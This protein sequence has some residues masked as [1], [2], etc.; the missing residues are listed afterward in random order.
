MRIIGLLQKVARWRRE[1]DYLIM[2][3]LLL[4]SVII[5]AGYRGVV[6]REMFTYDDQLPIYVSIAS[7]MTEH[8][9]SY[10]RTEAHL[11]KENPE[12][13]VYSA[14]GSKY[15]ADSPM[16][17]EIGW[18]LA[19]RVILKNGIKGFE[20][21]AR[22]IG[23]YQIMLDLIVVIILFFVGRKMFGNL[24]GFV[25]AVLYA[26]FRMPMVM[27]SEVKYYYW[28]IPISAVSLMFWVLIYGGMSRNAKKHWLYVSLFLY[29][30]F[31]GFATA[32]RVYF[33]LLPL[34]LV[35]FMLAKER[36]FKKVVL[37]FMIIMLGQSVFVIP[38]MINNKIH[39]RKFAVTVRG[40][41]H[42]FLQGVGLYPDNPWGI[43]D[44]GE[45]NLNVWGKA[46]GAP[47][48]FQSISR[49]EKWYR[50]RYFEMVAERPDIFIRNFSKHLKNG[51][52]YVHPHNYHFYGVTDNL[53]T[54]VRS[55]ITLLP[56]DH[57]LT[58]VVR[59]G[60][61]RSSPV[62]GLTAFYL[63]KGPITDKHDEPWLISALFRDASGG[64]EAVSIPSKA[65]PSVVTSPHDYTSVKLTSRE[66]PV[67]PS[68]IELFPWFFISASIL[69]LLLD[70]KRFWVL[71]AI[72]LQGLYLL[73]VV[74]SWFANYTPFMAGYIP[75]YIVL[76]AVSIMVYVKL[77]LAIMEGGLIWV[78][79]RERIGRYP[80]MVTRCFRG[81]ISLLD[82]G[83]SYPG[84]SK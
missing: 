17:S 33:L 5:A 76:L 57:Y 45:V 78:I 37:L 58:G 31:M 56:S 82:N 35:P 54:E 73:L 77:G 81:E 51:F 16:S 41:W 68:R 71:M 9:G 62:P 3:G 42:L 28:T 8:P 20:E 7:H 2:T 11:M 43:K 32:I 67:F 19:L 80:G 64:G 34:F 44:S 48:L 60:D 74:V 63:V 1:H 22:F 46:Q 75:V 18:G 72:L 53:D 65:P 69:L 21:V 84:V 4:A 40:H 47:D 10:N 23:R 70:R 24:G 61:P 36:S 30:V 49:S 27:M 26:L 59:T 15:R 38:Q 6:F 79:S 52:S 39:F 55:M 50:K 66:Q 29:G 13:Y 25:T 14:G 83:G 12:D